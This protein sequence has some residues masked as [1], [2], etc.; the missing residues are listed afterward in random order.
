[1]LPPLPI[2][3][4]EQLQNHEFVATDDAKGTLMERVAKRVVQA[5]LP[6]RFCRSSSERLRSRCGKD[7]TGKGAC[8]TKTLQIVIGE[9]AVVV[10]R[11]QPVVEVNLIKVGGDD[12]FAEFVSFHAQE[13]HAK[14]REHG[15][16]RLRDL[17]G[18]H[19]KVLRQLRQRVLA[20]DR[21]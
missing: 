12:F 8:A 15:D 17:I 16:Q 14:A 7:R 19:V 13:R 9:P 6:V 11:F 18:M 4:G 1:M 21:G 3:G 10:V 5:L 2:F 20:P